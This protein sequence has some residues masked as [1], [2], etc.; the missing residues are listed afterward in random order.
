[1]NELY[2]S[3][4]SNNTYTSPDSCNFSKSTIYNVK[5]ELNIQTVSGKKRNITRFEAYN[6]IRNNIS[7]YAMMM[8]IYESVDPELLFSTD[9]VSIVL[10]DWSKCPDVIITPK[11]QSYLEKNNINA[12]ITE[13]ITKRRC[14]TFSVTIHGNGNVAA[15]VIKIGDNELV[16]NKQYPRVLGPFDGNI[17]VILYQVFNEHIG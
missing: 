3:E 15:F 11:D 17:Y 16:T 6:N 2:N 4:H 13:N 8:I 14:V 5:K 12:A 7:L 10:N 9:D 1:M